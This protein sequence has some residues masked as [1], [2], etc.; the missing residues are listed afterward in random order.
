M[1]I[2]TTSKNHTKATVENSFLK[3]AFL[4]FLNIRKDNFKPQQYP[5]KP[6]HKMIKLILGSL[7]RFCEN[8]FSGTLSKTRRFSGNFKTNF[9]ST[10]YWFFFTCL[11]SINNQLLINIYY[12]QYRFLENEEGIM[13]MIFSLF[14]KYTF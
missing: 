7:H 12:L 1:K 13:F 9:L 2:S 4:N 14:S 5:L 3:L 11:F 6:L 10:F 8:I